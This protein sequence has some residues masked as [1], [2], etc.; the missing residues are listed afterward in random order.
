[1]EV[2]PEC[3]C[4]SDLHERHAVELNRFYAWCGNAG[5]TAVLSSRASTL[6]REAVIGLAV[7]LAVGLPLAFAIV[8]IAI[9][10]MRHRSGHNKVRRLLCPL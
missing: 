1:M 4:H 3:C 10:L 6:S 8:T 7:G 5:I 9:W 2:I